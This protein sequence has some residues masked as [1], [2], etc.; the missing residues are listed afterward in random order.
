[1]TDG[2]SLNQLAF[3]FSN[4]GFFIKIRTVLITLSAIEGPLS[5]SRE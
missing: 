1:M 4:T 2:G 3:L 5:V